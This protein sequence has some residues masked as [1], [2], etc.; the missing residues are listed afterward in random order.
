MNDSGVT[1]ELTDTDTTRTARTELWAALVY[2]TLYVAYLFYHPENEGEHWISMVIIPLILLAAARK[3]RSGQWAVRET[4]ASIG[5]SRSR[6]RVWLGPAIL[7][8]IA[9]SISQLFIGSKG[10]EVVQLFR[11]GKGFYLYPLV[12]ILLLFT[13]GIT[14]EVLFRGVLQTRLTRVLK[15]P[16]LGVLCVSV[17]FSVYHI[18]YAYLNPNWPSAGNLLAAT[19]AAFTNGMLGGLILGW[20]YEKSGHNLVA[21]VVVHS[22][23]NSLPAMTLIKFQIGG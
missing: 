7:I 3:Y 22:L 5:I 1:A 21:C 20:V 6:F 2:S 14:E 19:G 13:V 10:D 17:L 8:G 16:I 11:E 9:L 18:P 15:S 4:L 12:L 23:I